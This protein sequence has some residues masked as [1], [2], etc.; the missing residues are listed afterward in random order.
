[1][2]ANVDG[3]YLKADMDDFP[4]MRFTGKSVDIMC[5]MNQKYE[6]FVDTKDGNMVSYVRLVKALYEFVNFAVLWYHIF[7]GTLKEMGFVL[8]PYNP[9]IAICMFKGIHC[10][11]EWY[12]DNNKILHVNPNIVTMII[13][14]KIDD[15]FDKMTGF[16]R[17][18]AHVL[19]M[20]IWYSNVNTAVITMQEYLEE[21]IAKS[22]LEIM[23]TAATPVRKNLFELDD[24]AVHYTTVD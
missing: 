3:A 9:C 13:I 17:T 20:H 10:T 1:M 23:P 22:D 5:R 16:T 24:K 4:V 8:N 11:I 15:R 12:V 7:T 18:E 6:K 21:A 2:I 19:G 14:Q